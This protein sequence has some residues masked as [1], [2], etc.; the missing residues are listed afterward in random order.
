MPRHVTF[1]ETCSIILRSGYES[2]NPFNATYWTG[3][4]TESATLTCHLNDK[5]PIGRLTLGT[6]IVGPSGIGKTLTN[7]QLPKVF[8]NAN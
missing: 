2:R 3:L 6:G 4:P 7:C 8:L 1:A 5:Q